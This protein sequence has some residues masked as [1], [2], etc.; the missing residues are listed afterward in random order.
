MGP[1]LDKL[2]PC[3]LRLLAATVWLSGS[4][5]IASAVQHELGESPNA[6]NTFLLRPEARVNSLKHNTSMSYIDLAASK[7]KRGDP[8][9]TS[10]VFQTSSIRKDGVLHDWVIVIII[11]VA[12]ILVSCFLW[13]FCLRWRSR[14]TQNVA[15]QKSE[16][17]NGNGNGNGNHK[18]KTPRNN[19]PTNGHA[20]SS[21]PTPVKT[22]LAI[23][24]TASRPASEQLC[25]DLIVT[26]SNELRFTLV[27][28]IF[29]W[30][31]RSSSKVLDSQGRCIANAVGTCIGTDRMA[32]RGPTDDLL[33]EVQ[34]KSLDFTDQNVFDIFHPHGQLFGVLEKDTLNP[35]FTVTSVSGARLLVFQGDFRRKEIDI[36]DPASGD[37]LAQTGHGFFPSNRVGH[38][39]VRVASG[40]DAGLIIAC[41][42]AIDEAEH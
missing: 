19:T 36:T 28:N 8:L 24:S 9:R 35:T 38:Y 15:I 26:E 23:L 3:S 13:L 40:V 17:A 20:N 37:Q 16:E 30:T 11:V 42:L 10:R 39:Q 6:A 5:A 22:P 32:L 12:L 18:Q 21:P 7:R 34:R 41:C 14:Q 4:T 1:V 29:S 27:Q 2:V 31:P 33:C 25:P